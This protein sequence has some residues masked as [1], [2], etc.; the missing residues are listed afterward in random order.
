MKK[1]KNEYAHKEY[2]FRN[3]KVNKG[4]FFTGKTIVNQ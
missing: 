2:V 4:K 1:I 3:W